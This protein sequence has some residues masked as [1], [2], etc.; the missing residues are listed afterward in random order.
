[1]L[2]YQIITLAL[3]VSFAADS[4][5]QASCIWVAQSDQSEST[6]TAVE[7]KLAVTKP[8][9][10]LPVGITS[11]GGAVVGKK[12][13][14][15]GGHC[16]EAHNYYKAG[17]NTKLYRLDLEAP[18][19]WEVACESSGLQ[20]LAM[21]GHAGNLYRVGGFVARNKQG[22]DQD[23]HSTAGFAK[24]DFNKGEWV[25]QQPM[26]SPRSSLDAVVVGDTLYVVGG[27]N[28]R[29]DNETEWSDK[30]F[31]IDL[32]ADDA[33]WQTTDV[34]FNR[35]AL[36]VG[37]QGDKLYVVG[38]M[39]QKGGPTTE[40]QVYDI[41]TKAWSEGPK[42]PGDDGM[43]GFGSSCFNIGGRLVVSTY[44]GGV[45]N[46]ASDSNGWEKIHSLETGRFFHRL[47][48][49]SNNQFVLVGGANM[50]IGKLTDLEL[51]SFK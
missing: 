12:L 7:K 29:G 4:Q 39:R 26:P 20:G 23:L 48:P 3:M 36:S 18:T 32:S 33:K 13:F 43:T 25:D 22:E 15:Y 10:E 37:Y 31:S 34:P 17:Q 35:R 11:F 14:V 16:G 45:F 41:K 51:L 9:P 40:V 5:L 21:V 8:F 50:N 27:W 49:V 1:M 6:A 46:L 42:L 28:I 38:G 47:L 24:F 44:K 2:K 30:M 19:K